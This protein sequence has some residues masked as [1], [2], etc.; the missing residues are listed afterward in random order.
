VNFDT[1]SL[2][3]ASGIESLI[4]LIIALLWWRMNRK[5]RTLHMS[6]SSDTFR[7]M[8]KVDS[9]VHITQTSRKIEAGQ[10]LG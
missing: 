4:P 8:V 7:H 6:A 5:S 2:E 3:A 9:H 1:L 10:G